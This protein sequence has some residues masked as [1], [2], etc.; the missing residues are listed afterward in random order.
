MA[1][2]KINKN[3]E[4]TVDNRKRTVRGGA[5]IIV[6]AV[7]LTVLAFVNGWMFMSVFGYSKAD[8]ELQTEYIRTDEQFVELMGARIVG[9]EYRLCAD[10]SVDA[11]A[12]S[13]M[14]DVVLRGVLDGN[15]HKIT[16]VGELQAPIF[17]RI[18]DSARV[19]RVAFA[20]AEDFSH[21]PALLAYVNYG[22]VSDCTFVGG[23]AVGK[24]QY[25]SVVAAHNFGRIENCVVGAAFIA[26]GYSAGRTAV[27][28]LAAINYDGAEIESCIVE[29]VY[30]GG[31]KPIENPYFGENEVNDKL[32]YAVGQNGGK[33]FEVY[34]IN[35][36]HFNYS[37]DGKTESEVKNIGREDLTARFISALGFDSEC[38]GIEN[39]APPTLKRN[40]AEGVA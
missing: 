3:G 10:I 28:A 32:G 35:A 26:D 30:L 25:A 37:S 20:L 9:H 18:E 11:E 6:I 8:G 39:G 14:R 17:S 7:V 24:E 33:L 2:S 15:G 12:W 5:A 38:W 27:G 34:C 1:R 40:T 36:E 31:F 22:T 29:C 21:S 13:A 19:R 23:V 16:I 4:V